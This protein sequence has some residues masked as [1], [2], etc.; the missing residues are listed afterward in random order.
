MGGA[1]ITLCDAPTMEGG[2]WGS[3][4]TIV[5]ATNEG[6]YRVSA[7][8]GQP[9]TLARP[10]PDKGEAE[11]QEPKILPGG[12][13]VL[14]AIYLID[15]SYRTAILSL[16][17]GEKRILVEGARAP[18]YAPTGHLTYELTGTGTLMAVPFDPSELAVTGDAVPILEGVRTAGVITQGTADYSFSDDGTLVYINGESSIE[19]SL[20]WVDQNGVETQITDEKRAYENPEI[21]PDG[22]Q[23]VLNIQ[24][25]VWIYDL[26]R[27]S[28]SRSTLEGNLNRQPTWSPDGKWIAFRSNRNAEVICTE[29]LRMEVARQY[30]SPLARSPRPPTLGRPMGVL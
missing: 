2:S 3:D 21:S 1:T 26:E 23:V 14:F 16:E 13:A 11:Y 17:T 22:K 9:E 20:V 28:F 30:A 6:L 7:N 27:D 8:G 25:N 24:N 12:T 18:R 10:D 4:N 29:N 5:F 15:G 19:R